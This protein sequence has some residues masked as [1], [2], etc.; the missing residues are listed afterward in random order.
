MG[1]KDGWDEGG[2]HLRV[3]KITMEKITRYKLRYGMKFDEDTEYAMIFH[4]EL[5]RTRDY[6][7]RR[8]VRC[9][10]RIRERRP[11]ET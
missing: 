3:H 11:R 1:S 6:E 7:K 10:K 5:T 2:L 9:P 4:T 8:K